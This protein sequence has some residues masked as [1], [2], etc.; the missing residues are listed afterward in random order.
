[1]QSFARC[2]PAAAPGEAPYFPKFDFSRALS[3]RP[4]IG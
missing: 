4:P 1:M 3:R 2:R